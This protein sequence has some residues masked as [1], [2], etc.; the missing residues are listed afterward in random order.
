MTTTPPN[1]LAQTTPGYQS[2]TPSSTSIPSTFC[3]PLPI[4]VVAYN[5]AATDLITG[6][7]PSTKGDCKVSIYVVD[8]ATGGND[9]E[10]SDI[11]NVT[12]LTS[13]FHVRGQETAVGPKLQYSVHLDSDPK[14]PPFLGMPHPG[15]HW[16]FND[17]GLVDWTY[18][19]N[20]M[21]F[22]M[23]RCLNLSSANP[24]PATNAYQWAP[25]NQYFELFLATTTTLSSVDPQTIIDNAYLCYL[26]LYLNVEEIR[27]QDSRLDLVK[28][29]S[30]SPATGD[31]GDLIIQINHTD[32]QYISLNPQPVYPTT[33]PSGYAPLPTPAN[34]PELG[35][36]QVVLYEPNAAYFGLETTAAPPDVTSMT[37]QLYQIYE[38]WNAW[39]INVGY[40]SGWASSSSPGPGYADQKQAWS[41][42]NTLIG[43]I[44][45]TTNLQS[46]ANYLLM[47][48]IA[49]DPDGYH[50]STFMYK[51]GDLMYAGPLWDKN[52]SYGNAQGGISS[53]Y[54]SYEDW[55]VL[56]EYGSPSPGPAPWWVLL[57]S[58]SFCQTVLDT[59]NTN[60]ASGMPF[61]YDTIAE[62]VAGSNQ[63][64]KGGLMATILVSNDL[65]SPVSRD[66]AVWRPGSVADWEADVLPDSNS[67]SLL[68]YLNNRIDW[69][70]TNLQSMLEAQ[71]GQTLSG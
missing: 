41:G 52:K 51:D 58:Q 56:N 19:R 31:V 15:K 34:V 71:C 30:G 20:A 59:W 55:A 70:N 28:Y 60:T 2:N 62:F 64:G 36:N 11:A 24:D 38:W 22:N 16:I 63:D 53:W 42:T 67:G 48:E 49:K 8:S 12:A 46:F 6:I 4:V 66:L 13:K 33:V 61:N 69:I 21:A 35:V 14:N 29:S 18:M 47:A 3:S 26:G 39:A 37:D 45:Q 40:S 25:R 54:V 9:N 68:Y 5:G 65:G 27:K 32:S 10:L 50:R 7:N 1:Q 57:S 43:L 44:G 17:V 23:N